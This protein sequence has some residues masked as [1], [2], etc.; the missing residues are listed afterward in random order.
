MDLV[1]G[2]RKRVPWGCFLG[3][4]GACGGW[5]PGFWA[6]ASSLGVGSVGCRCLIQP[7][8]LGDEQAQK[9]KLG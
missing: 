4:E 7:L 1:G 2:R 8:I 5:F 9:K 6:V 3:V